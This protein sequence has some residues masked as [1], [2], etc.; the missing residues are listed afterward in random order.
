LCSDGSRKA[1]EK[2]IRL[3]QQTNS[4]NPFTSLQLCL[5]LTLPH[6]WYVAPPIQGYAPYFCARCKYWYLY[7]LMLQICK[8]FLASHQMFSVTIMQI[9]V[10][11]THITK[12]R[13]ATALAPARSLYMCLCL[14][15]G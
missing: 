13:T 7:I 1:V 8:I 3:L 12:I 6:W 4:L 2:L 15:K 5:N 11:I 14:R 9:D 10:M